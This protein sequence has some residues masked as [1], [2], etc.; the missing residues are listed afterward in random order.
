M[1]SRLPAAVGFASG[2]LLMLGSALDWS[3]VAY[4][5]RLDRGLVLAAGALMMVLAAVAA[6][7]WPRAL[8]LA[9]AA[10][11]LALNMGVVNFRDINDKRYEYADY[12]DASVGFGIYFVLVGGALALL[13]G[14]FALIPRRWFPRQAAASA[15][16]SAP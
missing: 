4:S 15:E 5:S 6:T 14:V 13:L 7:W 1:R 16:S 11:A 12:P 10:G 9:I 8:A 2:V 3:G